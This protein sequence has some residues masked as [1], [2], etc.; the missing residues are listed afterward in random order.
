[1]SKFEY[2]F[3]GSILEPDEG[4]IV[5]TV[6]IKP[7]NEGRFKDFCT[8][9]GIVSYLPLRKVCR[10][11]RVISKGKPYQYQSVI[12]RPMFPGYIFVKMTA[13]QRTA[14][15]QTGLVVRILG[16]HERPQGLLDEIRLIHQIEDIAKC[17]EV[18]FNADIKEGDRFLIDSGPWQGVYGWL[19]KKEK[20]FL[21]MV[22]LECVN[23]LVSATI[24]PSLYRMIPA[25]D[26]SATR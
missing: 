23:C 6:F 3:D 21:W 18:E 20:R 10:L 15:F 11:K 14:L 24:D 19:K 26:F 25:E 17:T 8:E 4:E 7:L 13:G 1:M 22:E 9:S 16:G 12:L 5:R 2:S